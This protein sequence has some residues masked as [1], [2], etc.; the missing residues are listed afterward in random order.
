LEVLRAEAADE[1]AT[2]VVERLRAGEDPWSFMELLP[3]VDE[4]VVLTLRA[5]LIGADHGRLPGPEVDYRMLRQIALA[6]PPL[7][8]AVWDML[9][10]PDRVVAER[11]P[12]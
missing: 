11:R 4:L 10:D 7:T 5:E 2:V 1:L 8:T 12:A 6:Y 9:A 3:T